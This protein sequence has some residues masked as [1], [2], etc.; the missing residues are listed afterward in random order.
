MKAYKIQLMEIETDEDYR[1]QKY[2]CMQEK[3]FVVEG[4]SAEYI[5]ERFSKDLPLMC[6]RLKEQ[7]EWEIVRE[8]EDRIK[9]R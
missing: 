5:F 7:D 3:F 2:K 8:V 9:C 1:P 4:Q 6:E